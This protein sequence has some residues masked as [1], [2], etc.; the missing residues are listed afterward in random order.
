[1]LISPKFTARIS[2]PEV[3]LYFP[4]L[5]F[6][7]FVFPVVVVAAESV[8]NGAA[9]PHGHIVTVLLS[10]VVILLAARIGAHLALCFGQ[11]EVLGEITVGLILGNLTL[12]Q[13]PSF[14]F[15]V[16]DETVSVL[17]ELGVILLLFEAGLET[18]ISDMLKVGASSL[19]VAVLGVVVPFFLGWGVSY[20]FIPE[21]GTLVHLFVGAT[22]CATSVGIS[23]RVLKDIGKIQS[24]EAKIILGAAVIDDVL[25]LLI[26]AVI[27]GVIIATE[28]GGSLEIAEIGQIFLSALGFLFF[29]ILLGRLFAAKYFRLVGYLKSHGLL[30]AAS[31]VVCF[32]FSYLASLVG[33]APIVGAFAAGLVLD[34]VH[35]RD[36]ASQNKEMTIEEL[37]SPLTSFLV[38]LFFVIMGAK[39]DLRAFGDASTLYFAAGLTVAAIIGKQVCSFGVLEKELDRIAVGFGMI[40]RGEV[41]LIFAAIG[42]SLILHGEPVIDTATFG[43]VVIMV[44]FTTMVTPPLLKWRF[45]K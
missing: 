36:L 24:K 34:K 35:Y 27:S 16:K 18:N 40:P 4:L 31:L 28:A 25:G 15:L 32:G 39:V 12:L 23:V 44:M 38:P 20:L 45:A 10:L 6:S 2:R 9:G 33:L 3:F 17:S 22:L 19:L 29:S 26:L 13:G 37:I 43:A 1:M 8:S 42:A 41:G 21:A 14:D 11:P 5:I 30:L 7:P